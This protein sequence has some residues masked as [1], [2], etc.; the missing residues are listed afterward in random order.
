MKEKINKWL[1]FSARFFFLLFHVFYWKYP[2][3][4]ST[5]DKWYARYG[6][7]NFLGLKTRRLLMGELGVKV[8]DQGKML[9]EKEVNTLVSD[10]NMIRNRL[11]SLI[12]DGRYKE[13]SD[14]T[15]LNEYYGNSQVDL[16]KYSKL[17]KSI[18][19]LKREKKLKKNLIVGNYVDYTGSLDAVSNNDYS[20]HSLN[21]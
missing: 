9:N 14:S 17:E 20:R 11:K 8:Q 21:V 15:L 4:P 13:I 2:F 7:N 16:T 12:I 19:S 18:D 10:D 3:E 1:I 5:F 6:F